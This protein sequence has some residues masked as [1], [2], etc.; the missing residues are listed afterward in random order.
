MKKFLIIIIVLFFVVSFVCILFTIIAGNSFNFQDDDGDDDGEGEGENF[1]SLPRDTF[2]YKALLTDNIAKGF[3]RNSNPA[4][5]G[6]SD[7][8]LLLYNANL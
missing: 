7:S 1:S 3:Y 2:L 4:V 8:W 5:Q 6:G